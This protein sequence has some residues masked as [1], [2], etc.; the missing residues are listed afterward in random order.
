M[1]QVRAACRQ[2]DDSLIYPDDIKARLLNYIYS[3]LLFSDADVDF[4]V[5]TWNR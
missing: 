3:T 4:D 2:A 1:G 5:I